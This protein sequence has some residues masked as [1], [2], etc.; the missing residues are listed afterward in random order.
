MIVRRYLGAAS[1][2]C[3]LAF[4]VSGSALAADNVS[5][6]T[7]GPG[8]NQQVVID[9]SSNVSVSNTNIVQV[10]NEN[11]QQATSGGASA[12]S[13][14]SVGGLVQSG[15]ASNNNDTT[16]TIGVSNTP[17]VPP[18]VGPGTGTNP[19]SGSTGGVSNGSTTGGGSVLGASTVGGLGAGAATLP[20]V[21]ASVPMDVSALRAAWHPQGAAPTAALAKGSR[22]FTG[23]MLLTATLL[24]LLGALGSAWYARR[25]EERV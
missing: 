3:G 14:T 23:A 9:N 19:G 8:S 13:N 15:N 12:N 22:L 4:G 25:R 2:V 20:A 5:I 16:T 6:G 17:G 24:S 10:T 18:V 1:V 21:G 11:V 7:T